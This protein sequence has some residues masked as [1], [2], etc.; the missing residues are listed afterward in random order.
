MF[1]RICI[2]LIRKYQ[3]GGGGNRFNVDCNFEPSCS[4]YA[5]GCL[6]QHGF[7]RA[8]TLIKSRLSRCRVPDQVHKIADP[9]PIRES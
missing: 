4:H 3:A 6:Q 8:L 1:N 9:V 2:S 5:V 7:W